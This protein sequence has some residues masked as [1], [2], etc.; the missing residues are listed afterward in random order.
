MVLQSGTVIAISAVSLQD[1]MCN[2]CTWVVRSQGSWVLLSH[3]C[4]SQVL[5]V[6]AVPAQGTVREFS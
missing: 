6:G 3:R 4:V 2:V 5:T 1:V